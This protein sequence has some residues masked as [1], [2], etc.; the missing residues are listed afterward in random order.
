MTDEKRGKVK[1]MRKS[2]SKQKSA[3][4]SRVTRKKKKANKNSAGNK[5]LRKFVFIF[6]A[7]FF[8]IMGIF[9][10]LATYEIVNFFQQ[11]QP[12]HKLLRENVS[13]FGQKLNSQEPFSILLIGTDERI[14]EDSRGRADTIMVVTVNPQTKD[15]KIVSIPRDTLI[16]LPGT[17]DYIPDK[18]NSTYVYGYIPYLTTSVE[19]LLKIPIDSYAI[20][21]FEGLVAL[22]DAVNGVEIE[23]DM[24]FSIKDDKT[25]EI[26]E[27]AEGRHILD[28]REALGYARM[29]K[30][31]PEGDFGRQKRQQ[32]II[33]SLI[34]RLLRF[35]SFNNYK[36]IISALGQ[37]IETSVTSNQA[38]TIFSN[39]RQAASDIDKLTIEG[40][41][42]YVF[43]PHYALEVYIYDLDFFSL[44]ELRESLQ[45][46]LNAEDFEFEL[47]KDFDNYIDGFPF[48][49][50][51]AIEELGLTE[52][53]DPESNDQADDSPDPM[54]SEFLLPNSSNEHADGSSEF[55]DEYRSPEEDW[56]D[57]K[58]NQ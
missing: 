7:L 25:G 2:G 34:S 55:S 54:D 31:D 21:N 43:F 48:Y 49:S 11:I 35:D 41:D 52:L 14:S 19:D 4:L 27:I 18:I 57:S 8:F 10:G 12:E 29:R 9:N 22:V 44:K 24:A 13:A 1:S 28:G 51:N 15:A 23:S 16:T 33:E 37:N 50:D 6:F 5:T 39:Y 36:E 26:Q 58:P 45:N 53:A 30:E 56:I 42:Q 17:S 46:H 32:Q 3:P 38:Q 47:S 40:E 20:M